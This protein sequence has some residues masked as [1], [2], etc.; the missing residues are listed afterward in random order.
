MTDVS[1]I[2]A[3]M[4]MKKRWFGSTN[5]HSIL[6]NSSVIRP[7]LGFL[8]LHSHSMLLEELQKHQTSVL[9]NF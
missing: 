4:K 8:G 9:A 7:K 6:H 2:W 3:E 5:K 1:K